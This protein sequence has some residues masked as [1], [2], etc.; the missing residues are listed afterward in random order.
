MMATHYRFLAGWALGLIIFI[1]GLG[2]G[3]G[4]GRAAAQ[5]SVEIRTAQGTTPD[6]GRH[7]D[8]IG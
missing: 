5:L 1:A 2:V 8:G 7:S 4:G 6:I 3:Y